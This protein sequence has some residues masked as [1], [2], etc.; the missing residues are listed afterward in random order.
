MKR[1]T[2]VL[3]EQ[4]LSQLKQLAAKEDRTL[5]D[6]VDEILRTG[7]AQRKA[8]KKRITNYSLPSYPM[9][10]ALVNVADRDQLE[11]QMRDR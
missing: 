9:G 3:D 4:R 11:E 10:G 6:L 7:I 2:L 5:S 1:T 8:S